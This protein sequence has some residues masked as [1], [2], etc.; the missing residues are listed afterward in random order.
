LFSEDVEKVLAGKSSVQMAL[1]INYDI[2]VHKQNIESARQKIKES[3]SL[4]FPRVNLN[5]NSSIFNSS[6]PMIIC[7]E[8]SQVPI[9]LSETKKESVLLYKTCS[10]PRYLF[11]RKNKSYK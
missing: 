4:Y 8:S 11:R 3:I 1:S 10:L 7:A 2:L 9:Y 5:F 6:A